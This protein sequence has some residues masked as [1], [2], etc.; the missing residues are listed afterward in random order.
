MS[1][2]MRISHGTVQLDD[3]ELVGIDFVGC[4]IT[5]GPDTKLRD[6]T[7]DASSILRVLL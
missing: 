3:G 5:L 1:D 7:I 6:C 2:R 4:E